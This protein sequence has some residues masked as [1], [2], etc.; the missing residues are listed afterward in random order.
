MLADMYKREAELEGEVMTRKGRERDIDP[1]GDDDDSMG[2][3]IE[4]SGASP[5]TGRVCPQI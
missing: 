1:E 5:G 2:F 4:L 3:E